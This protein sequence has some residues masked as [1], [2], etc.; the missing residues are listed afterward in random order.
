MPLV[1]RR[2]LICSGLSAL[3]ARTTLMDVAAATGTPAGHCRQSMLDDYRQMQSYSDV[4]DVSTTIASRQSRG[5]L[6][7]AFVAP[8]SFAMQ[9]GLNG[10]IASVGLCDGKTFANWLDGRGWKSL[11]NLTVVLGAMQGATGIMGRASLWVSGLL[12]DG[13]AAPG[14]S[15]PSLANVDFGYED[16]NCSLLRGRLDDASLLVRIDSTSRLVEEIE[17]EDS[18]SR[19][20][21][22]IGR[23]HV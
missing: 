12:F 21:I 20:K 9:V 13:T 16:S 23:A 22:K 6:I 7:T 19:S 11:E 4:I 10:R 15:L 18:F 2:G 5:R 3:L 14:R 1:S 17:V 8:Q